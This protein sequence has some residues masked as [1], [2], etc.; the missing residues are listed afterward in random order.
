[1]LDLCASDGSIPDSVHTQPLAVPWTF[2][3]FGCGIPPIQ[4]SSLPGGVGLGGPLF[5]LCILVLSILQ[6]PG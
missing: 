1:M 4:L 2:S 5:N 3:A 6:G